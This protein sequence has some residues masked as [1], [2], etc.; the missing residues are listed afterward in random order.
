MLWLFYRLPIAL[1]LH[2]QA[3]QKAVLHGDMQM[4]GPQ[5]VFLPL[6]LSAGLLSTAARR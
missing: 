4:E 2:T 5:E 3:A 6:S 1:T